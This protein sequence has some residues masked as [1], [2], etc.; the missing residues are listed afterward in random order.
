MMNVMTTFHV[1]L[2]TVTPSSSQSAAL[3]GVVVVVLIV[4]GLLAAAVWTFL[5]FRSAGPVIKNGVSSVR[6]E[7]FAAEVLREFQPKEPSVSDNEHDDE[8]SVS[9][10]TPTGV[11][12]AGVPVTGPESPW[13]RS[14][15]LDEVLQ[16]LADGIR[17]LADAVDQAGLHNGGSDADRAGRVVAAFNTSLAALPIQA[18]VAAGLGNDGA[19]E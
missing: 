13:R 8:V 16:E 10:P 14:E 9:G 19:S 12:Y 1:T 18:L 3:V 4:A 15:V 7:I 11:F 6:A 2:A 5:R 17:H